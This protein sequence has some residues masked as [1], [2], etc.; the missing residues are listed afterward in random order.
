MRFINNTSQ[1][2]GTYS[3]SSIDFCNSCNKVIKTAEI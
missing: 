1:T 2:E 3:S